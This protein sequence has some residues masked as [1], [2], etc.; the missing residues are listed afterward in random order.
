MRLEGELPNRRWARARR[1]RYEKSIMVGIEQASASP[2]VGRNADAAHFGGFVNQGNGAF[3][4]H[5]DDPIT[6]EVKVVGVAAY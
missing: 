3:A 4:A 1:H 5:D 6:K 2:P